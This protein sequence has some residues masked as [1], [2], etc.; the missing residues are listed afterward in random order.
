MTLQSTTAVQST[1]ALQS[2]MAVQSTKAV[3]STMVLPRD[4]LMTDLS[5]SS[6]SDAV[7]EI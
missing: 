4:S 3:Q 7:C 2:T 5:R 1:T 6:A